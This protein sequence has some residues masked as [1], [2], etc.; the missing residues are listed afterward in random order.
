MPPGVDVLDNCVVSISDIQGQTICKDPW[1]LR[2]MLLL[3]A[4]LC[5]L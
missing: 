4:G 1:N 2:S 3:S 5:V